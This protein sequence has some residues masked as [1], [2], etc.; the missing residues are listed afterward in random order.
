MIR[1]EWNSTTSSWN[2]QP[3]D[4]KMSTRFLIATILS[5][6]FTMASP[7]P[8]F[9]FQDSPFSGQFD[10]LLGDDFE[11]DDSSPEYAFSG[12]FTIEEGKR[13][14][15]LNVALDIKEG[16][17]GYSQK[18]LSGQSPTEIEVK[19]S[20]DFKVLGK[21][22][23]DK[24]PHATTNVLGEVEEFDDRVVWS[25]PIEITEGVTPEQLTINI[26]VFG[27]VCKQSCIRFSGD[28]SKIIAKFSKYTKSVNA[29]FSDHGTVA[30]KLNRHTVKPGESTTLTVTAKMSPDWHIYKFEPFK[31]ENMTP[32]PTIIYFTKTSGLQV[33][34]PIASQDPTK[35]ETG[36]PKE[37][38]S[39]YHEGEV[40]W[41]LDINA[42]E[43][44]ELGKY[45]VEGKILFQL[46]TD[47]NCDRPMVL[48][49]S[50]PINVAANSIDE[51]IDCA[52]TI[53]N[54]DRDELMAMSKS[55][56]QDQSEASGVKA[57]I[58]FVDLLQYLALAFGA[59]LIL[60]AMPCVLP[61]IGL[62]VMSFVQQA[63]ENRG[64]V[65][66]LNLVFSLGL[67]TVFWILASLSAFAG[68]G[69]GDWLTKSLTGAIIITAVVFAF[70]LSMLG[71]WEIPIPGLS[72]SNSLSKQ[73]EEE[74]LLGAFFLGILTTILAT[75][76]TGPMLIPAVTVT[77]GQPPWVAYLIF[78]TIGLGMAM[79]YLLV[80][81][82]PS[83]IS[84]LPR[85]GA[86]M[87]TFKQIM[88]FVLMATVVFL[89]AP[90]SSEP[91]SDY[92]VAML[93]VLLL[94]GF[95]CWWIGRTSLAAE[96]SDQLKAWG[97]GLGIIAVGSFVAFTYL[98]PPEYELDWQQY[99][100]AKLGELLDEN[101]LVFID[102]T[103]PN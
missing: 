103:G 60:N 61:V 51:P 89:M 78:T 10:D 38:Y 49:F 70:G 97:T 31:P 83:L 79:P 5:V 87:T 74:G 59:G 36:L 32:Q 12:D 101:R 50:V 86:W 96:T 63:G 54:E 53:S 28:A 98:V 24:K 16:W 45:I 58:P 14:G 80:G 43:D 93:T 91:R 65:F 67:L 68:Y 95:G 72:G 34:P 9:S 27:Q 57:A 44:L 94:I 81:I 3:I 41:K 42:P 21:F 76:C 73:S 8:S 29:Y 11:D 13:T 35:H 4:K 2:N 26:Q 47:Q 20:N 23:P 40:D 56:W 82:F 25:A 33:S 69:W 39:Y 18:E 52:L 17:H 66:L 6:V 88:G 7:I 90:F 77:A 55:F 102:F 71:V 75:P 22:T 92:L 85:P 1:K 48:N 64:R 30:G 19:P 100:K 15:T 84:W 46:C 99:S 62:K 37:P